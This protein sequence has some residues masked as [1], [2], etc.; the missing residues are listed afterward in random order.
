MSFGAAFGRPRSHFHSRLRRDPAGPPASSASQL[1]SVIRSCG[2][3]VKWL[4]VVFAFAPLGGGCSSESDRSP[5]AQPQSST[6]Q[7]S[8]TSPTSESRVSQPSEL[9][10]ADDAAIARAVCGALR[11]YVNELVDVAN[12][13]V[14][15][16]GG[17]EPDE[18]IS[19]VMD[20]FDT[21]L[22]AIDGARG[23]FSDMDLPPV[24]E[25]DVLRSELLA[26]LDDATAELVDERMSFETRADELAAGSA[27]GV[28][29]TWFNAIEKAMSVSE[30]EIYRYERVEFKRAFLDEPD[31]RHVIQ[32]FEINGSS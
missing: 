27:Q 5:G 3:N 11:A 8:T 1:N 18:R 22:D 31:C 14:E 30:P 23:A 13:A 6:G 10:A 20:G 29:G 25:R 2:V 4:A 16:I 17:R 19:L 15:G 9:T 26:G 32:Q 12:A 21:A 7:N 28:A 24:P